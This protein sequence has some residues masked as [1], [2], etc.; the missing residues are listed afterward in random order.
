MSNVPFNAF[1][2]LVSY[3]ILDGGEGRADPLAEVIEAQRADIVCIVE[4]D[5]IEVIE[6][7]A[8]RLKMDFIHA[9]GRKSA[10]ALMSRW[11]ISKTI[12]H[13]LLRND[14]PEKSFLEAE[15]IEPGGRDWSIGVVH[16]HA[17]ARD[18]DEQHRE[19][20]LAG[21]LE[22]FARHRSATRPHLLV[23]DFNANSPYQQ[24]DPARCYPTTR[25]E[26]EENGG[27]IPRR[28]VQRILDAGYV[29][30]FRAFDAHKAETNGTFTTQFP[31]Q[32]VDYSF[33]FGFETSSIQNAWI[34]YDR[35]AKY[36]SDHFPIGLEIV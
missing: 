12:N 8:N 9:P 11:P 21:V 1:M 32:R 35:L 26:W 2:R 17:H 18:E 36:A 4:A 14:G 33:A 7:I 27:Q 19:R 31:G 16:L 34:E 20:K 13:G 23:G 3:N 28:V 24:I 10:A 30:A 25:K 15:V 6:R 5:K 29:D 22:V